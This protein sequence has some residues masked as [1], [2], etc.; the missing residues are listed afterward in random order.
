MKKRSISKK[1]G[2]LNRS[3]SMNHIDPSEDSDSA[4]KIFK[5]PPKTLV[6]KQ[7]SKSP[8]VFNKKAASP[9]SIQDGIISEEEELYSNSDS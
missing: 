7:R 6:N 9:Y 4:V 5:L 2:D 3:K 8:S 1:R